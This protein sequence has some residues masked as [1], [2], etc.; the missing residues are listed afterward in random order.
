VGNIAPVT[1]FFHRIFS[2]FVLFCV[3][4]YLWV[5]WFSFLHP[6]PQVSPHPPLQVSLQ[7][8]LQVSSQ[9]PRQLPLQ[10]PLQSARADSGATVAPNPITASTGMTLALAFRNQRRLSPSFVF[11][12]M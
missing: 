11:F 12:V 1:V 5:H 3:F 6:P 8:P 10:L 7:V 4:A 9:V 2:V